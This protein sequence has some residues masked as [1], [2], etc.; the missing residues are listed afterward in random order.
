MNLSI[1]SH[2]KKSVDSRSVQLRGDYAPAAHAK[3]VGDPLEQALRAAQLGLIVGRPQSWLEHP[4][5]A[6]ILEAAVRTLDE[7]FALVPEGL[8]SIPL[9]VCDDPGQPEVDCETKAYLLSRHVV[10][11]A[12]YQHFVDADGYRDMT[13]W[14]EEIWPQLIDFKDATGEPGPRYWRNGCHDRRLADHPVVGVSYYEAAAYAQW[15]GYRLPT[16]AEWQ[17]AASWRIRSSAHVHRSYPWGDSLDVQRC[18]IWASG[19]G[20]TM[21][22]D[23]YPNGAAPNGVQQLIG[24]VWEWTNSEFLCADTKGQR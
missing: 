11:N 1:F 5:F 2:T 20:G 7:R 13:L 3:P 16:E 9:T 15:A 21:P 22:V 17:M 6:S 14:P 19:H 18:N 24:N 12:Q 4:R 8:V 23:A 10:T